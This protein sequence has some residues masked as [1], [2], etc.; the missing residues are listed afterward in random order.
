MDAIN[1]AHLSKKHDELLDQLK[2]GGSDSDRRNLLQQRLVRIL[3]HRLAVM[4]N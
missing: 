3:S 4:Q 2:I 1:K